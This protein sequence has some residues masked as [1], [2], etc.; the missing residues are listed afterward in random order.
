MVGHLLKIRKA[1]FIGKFRQGQLVKLGHHTS[2]QVLR[3]LLFLGQIKKTTLDKI[4]VITLQVGIGFN[5]FISDALEAGHFQQVI[6]AQGRRVRLSRGVAAGRGKAVGPGS[7][8]RRFGAPAADLGVVAAEPARAV[9]GGGRG[10]RCRIRPI[11]R[12]HHRV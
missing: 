11:A 4:E 7:R 3:N 5:L 2:P 1:Q 12:C 9:V 10:W 6:A 8:F